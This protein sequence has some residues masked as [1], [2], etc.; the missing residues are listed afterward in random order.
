MSKY[1][2]FHVPD[3][4]RVIYQTLL[5]SKAFVPVLAILASI[6]SSVRTV[7]AISEIYASSGSDG[8]VV[9]ITALAFTIS[10]EGALFLLALAQENQHI[11]WRQTKKKRHVLT[12]RT[13]GRSIAVRIGFKEPLSYDQIPE[14]DGGIQTLILIAF[15]F[16]I[17][18]NFYLGMKPILAVIGSTTVQSFIGKLLNADANVQLMFIVDLAGVLFPPFMAYKAGHLTARFAA[19]VAASQNRTSAPRERSTKATSEQ[20]VE[21]SSKGARERVIEHLN[22]H[23]ED[24]QKVSQQKLAKQLRVS[25]GTVN[26]VYKELRSPER[27][28]E[29]SSNGHGNPK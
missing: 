5:W 4:R 12:L 6:A 14:S 2:R 23:P 3:A 9:V 11:R 18:T 26:S 25:V 10:V 29:H 20:P 8:R 16:A 13:I 15:S 7:Q 27:S 22:E 17:A 19:E 1:I 21:R 28:I 24:V